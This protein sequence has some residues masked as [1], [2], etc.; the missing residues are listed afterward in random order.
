MP[1]AEEFRLSNA[2]EF[3]GREMAVTDWVD[4]DQVQV[5]VFGEVTRWA[6]W[7]HCD[8]ERCADESPY[9]GTILHGFFALSLITYFMKTSGLRPADA[10]YSL[11]YG[12]DKVRV[13]RPVLVGDGVRL[14][15]RVTLIDV[16]DK[17][18]GR[19]IF[20]TGNLIE[21]DGSDEP[22][23]YAEYLNYWFPR[24]KDA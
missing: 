10:A 16:I 9:G 17:G 1:A 14:R 20:K 24:P 21:V 23:V 6:T 15:D 5:N 12:M 13:L 3:V 19:R 2:H 8:P 4:I 7:M 22:M 18:E 11:N